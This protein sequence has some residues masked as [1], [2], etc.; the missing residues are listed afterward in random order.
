MHGF[1]ITVVVTYYNQPFDKLL[2]TLESA[3]RQEGVDFEIVVA[4]DCSDIDLSSKMEAFFLSRRFAYYR[5]SRLDSNRQTIGNILCAL[6]MSHGTYIKTIGA[7]DAFPDPYVLRDIVK[8]CRVNSVQAGFAR[9][10]AF[11]E[12]ESGFHFKNFD[13]P[14]NIDCYALPSRVANRDLLSH[15]IEFGDWVPGGLQFFEKQTF[16][17]LL[18]ELYN[19]ASLRYCE[20]FAGT[21][22]TFS[23]ENR[24][25]LLDRVILL[26]EFG[27]GISTSGNKASAKRMYNDHANLYRFI[28]K[29]R[30][31]GKRYLIARAFFQVKRFI[32]LYLPVYGLLQKRVANSYMNSTTNRF[33]S[34][35]K[36]YFNSCKAVLSSDYE[37]DIK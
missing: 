22:L 11:V 19:K 13:A 29:I 14:R 27:G 24:M 26:Y 28:G 32:A 9:C 16:V 3:I 15:Q 17:N 10:I 33:T 8:F 36:D 6:E 18:D 1:D 21:I 35:M 4:D 25:V 7:G 30:P 31:Y 12:S 20:D 5:I 23:D 37:T 34:T 2:F